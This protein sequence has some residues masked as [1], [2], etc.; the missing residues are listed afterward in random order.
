MS[1]G[2]ARS[3]ATW[4]GTKGFDVNTFKDLDSGRE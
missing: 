1:A 3:S 2:R 4:E